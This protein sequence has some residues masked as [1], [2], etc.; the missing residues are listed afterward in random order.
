MSHEH[1]SPLPREARQYQGHRAGLVTRVIAA[2]ID[3]G[4]VGVVLCLGYAGLAGFLFLLS[5]RDFSFPDTNLILSMAAA[6][7]VMVVYLTFAWWFSGRTYGNLLMG[8]RVVNHA[9]RRLHLGGA[10]VRAVF[11]TV[12]PIGLM[13]IAF[14]RENRSAQDLVLRTSVLYD[15]KPRGGPARRHAEDADPAHEAAPEPL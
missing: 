15:W 9:G 11:C 8:L 14:S 13:W 2:A 6:F 7:G 10:F 3:A 4:V 1:L 12:F 5:P